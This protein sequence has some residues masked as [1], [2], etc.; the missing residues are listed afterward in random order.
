MKSAKRAAI[1]AAVGLIA[2]GLAAAVGAMA[3]MK[4]DFTKLNTQSFVTNTYPVTQAFSRISVD[5]AGCDVRLLPSEDGS[6]QIVCSESDKVSYSVAVENDTLTIVQQDERQWY[7]CIGVYWGDMALEVYLPQSEFEALSVQAF[8]GNLTVP[9]GFVFETAE[10][11]STSG[12][13][14]FSAAVNGTLS[15]ETKSGDLYVGQTA[16]EQLTM[17]SASGRITVEAVEAGAALQVKTESGAIRLTDIGCGSAAI[18]TRSGAVRFSDVIANQWIHIESTSG[19]VALRRCDADSLWIQTR[20][21]E[22]SGSL[23][24]EKVFLTETSSGDVQVPHSTSG[25]T[26]E[27][28]TASGDIQFELAQD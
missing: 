6:C 3:A 1:L 21:G 15:V 8:S 18:E 16:P 17:Q 14:R 19:G 10:I 23:L 28:I 22:V 5:S 2:V 4:F 25:G 27:I 9:E 26:C 24:S 13:V 12:Y 7:D 11:Q 20:S